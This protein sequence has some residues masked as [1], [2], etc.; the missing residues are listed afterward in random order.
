M[1]DL[2]QDLKRDVL[3]IYKEILVG[4][5]LAYLREMAKTDLTAKMEYFFLQKVAELLEDE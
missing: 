2:T 3:L 5:S 1:S 4:E